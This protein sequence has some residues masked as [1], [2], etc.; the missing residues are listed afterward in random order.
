MVDINIDLSGPTLGSFS[1][2]IAAAEAKANKHFNIEESAEDDSDEGADED[3]VED[4]DS[5]DGKVVHDSVED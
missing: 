2:D 5:G 4:E 1:E 3:E